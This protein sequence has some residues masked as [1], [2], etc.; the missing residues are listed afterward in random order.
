MWNLSKNV[1]GFLIYLNK[2]QK[3]VSVVAGKKQ[4]FFYDKKNNHEDL[5]NIETFGQ[6]TKRVIGFHFFNYN[7]LQINFFHSPC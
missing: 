7:F 3:Q 2:S 6:R 4:T 1:Y 5:D